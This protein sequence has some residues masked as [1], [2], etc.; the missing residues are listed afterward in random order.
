MRSIRGKILIAITACAIV[1]VL[2]SSILITKTGADGIYDEAMARLEYQSKEIGLRIQALLT[3]TE[4]AVDNTASTLENTVDI[5][6]FEIENT[7]RSL[8]VNN[9]KRILTDVVEN[10]EGTHEA[11][12]IFNPELEI[13][14][15]QLSMTTD[16]NDPVFNKVP[17]DIAN[18]NVADE[19]APPADIAW[20]FEAKLSG[21]ANVDNSEPIQGIWSEPYYDDQAGKVL[22]KYVK[23][24]YRYFTFV[25]VTGITFDYSVIENQV[26]EE[27]VYTNGYAYLLDEEYDFLAHKTY[28]IGSNLMSIGEGVKPLY[29]AMQNKDMDIQKYTV[30]GEDK[31]S[32]FV[33]LSNGWVVGVTPPLD[34]IFEAR[35]SMITIF[36]MVLIVVVLISAVIA[37]IVSTKMAKPLHMVSDALSMVSELNLKSDVNIKQ[38][39]EAKDETGMMANQLDKMKHALKEIVLRL[40]GLSSELFTESENMT[41]ISND[42]MD[43]INTVYQSVED[44]T[45]GANDQAEEAQKSNE[46][47][48]VL[49]T[50]I[51]TVIES[52]GK[53]LEYSNNTKELN[54]SSF[55]VVETLR[56]STIENAENTD[57]MEQNVAELLRKSNQI[58][59][60]VNVI[61]NIASQTNLL[62]LNASIEAA[63][64]GDAGRGFAVVAEE[65]RKLAVQTSESTSKIEE[66]TVEI[67]KQVQ[68]VSD[69]IH[70]ART[71]VDQTE[72]VTSNVEYSINNTIESV[73]GIIGL[74]EQLT[75]ELNEVNASKDVVVNSIGN[76]A[77]VTEES[78]AAADS[79]SSMMENQISNMDQIQTMTSTISRVAE[80]IEVEMNKFKVDTDYSIPKPVVEEVV[81]EEEFQE[82]VVET[83]EVEEEFVDEEV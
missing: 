50:K 54:E 32:G 45:L 31:I 48:L 74:I 49:N 25:G 24:I 28:E 12:F 30:N 26:N 79:V 40:Q 6:K 5:K 60:I 83:F 64:A 21:K 38:L 15:H 1:S 20:F 56:Q 82:D 78:S 46:E 10:L 14:T 53:V 65:I 69:N 41:M 35:D 47:L 4:V 39:Q 63:R 75:K 59:E 16:P 80:M 44:L 18:F 42:S 34:E 11:F 23:P 57:V 52:V 77:A 9:L 51:N 22:I 8:T 19:T 67:E 71:N 13:E 17:I 58:D 62:A 81:A 68:V 70:V 43:S 29:E 37:I 72:E 33:R 55:E 3:S 66:F 2:V 76:I 27:K 73:N 36:I 61:K 7:Y